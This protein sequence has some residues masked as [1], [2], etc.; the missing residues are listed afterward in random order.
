MFAK[1]IVAI[2]L[3]LCVAALVALYFVFQFAYRWLS[4]FDFSR[5]FG[6]QAAPEAADMPSMEGE[7]EMAV[8]ADRR[9]T[10]SQARELMQ[11]YPQ[12]IVLDVRSE[13]EFA[14]G[15]VRGA[16]LLPG[17]ELYNRARYELPDQEALILVY[18]R[19]GMRAQVAVQLL[20][21]MGYAHVY[22]FG[23]I[24]SWPYER[25]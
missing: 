22:D 8:G 23:G 24:L 11:R 4:D 7:D 1:V 9:I 14:E 16:R 3:L 20:L 13:A 21:G 19:S 10:A 25:E 5:F 18:C 15:R 6:G 17:N 12:A 2:K